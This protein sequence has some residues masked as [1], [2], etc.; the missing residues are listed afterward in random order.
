MVPGMLLVAL[1]LLMGIYSVI[2]DL[3]VKAFS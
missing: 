3:I 2:R 1:L